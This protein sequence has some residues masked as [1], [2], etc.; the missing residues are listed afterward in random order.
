MNISMYLFGRNKSRNYFVAS[1]GEKLSCE[2]NREILL[3]K[4][5]HMLLREIIKNIH[6]HNFGCGI[7]RFKKIST[8]KIA[9]EIMNLAPTPE[10]IKNTPPYSWRNFGCGLRL[11]HIQKMAESLGIKL[12]FNKRDYHFKGVYTLLP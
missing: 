8:N 2:L 10:A 3:D 6:D 7:A 4:E 12:S 1:V 9:F 5:F 11:Q